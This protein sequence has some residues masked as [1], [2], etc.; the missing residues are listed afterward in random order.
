[1]SLTRDQSAAE[2]LLQEAFCRLVDQLTNREAPREILPWMLRVVSNLAVSRGRRQR[3]AD[4]SIPRLVDRDTGLSAETHV[5]RREYSDL[6]NRGLDALSHDERAALLMAAA[7]IDGAGIA[8]AIGRSEGATRTMLFRARLR[9]QRLID[10]EG[11][12]DA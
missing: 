4:R 7:G 12:A 9:L 8:H 3:V 10:T 1:M 2:D 6:V 11:D 5:L